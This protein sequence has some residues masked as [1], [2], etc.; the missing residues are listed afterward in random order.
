MSVWISAV[1]IK[2][3]V[4]NSWYIELQFDEVIWLQASVRVI[5]LL[6]TVTIIVD[7]AE[8]GKGIMAKFKPRL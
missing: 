1:I 7:L 8:L 4:A 2:C 5:T 3:V 6:S